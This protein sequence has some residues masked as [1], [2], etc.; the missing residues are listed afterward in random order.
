MELPVLHK[1]CDNRPLPPLVPAFPRKR[2]APAE[3]IE[4]VA[5]FFKMFA[6]PVRLRIMSLLAYRGE[7][8]VSHL[9]KALKLPQSTVSRHLAQLREMRLIRLRYVG[10]STYYGLN[11]P[12][13]LS[14]GRL[15]LLD[16]F[17]W[18]H[19]DE[20]GCLGSKRSD[21]RNL[22]ALTSGPKFKGGDNVY[23][24]KRTGKGKVTP[25]PAMVLKHSRERI[26]ITTAGPTD[27]EFREIHVSPSTLIKRW[28]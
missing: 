17:D 13:Q 27:G 1:R 6:D 18:T 8:M 26:K 7:V 23:W 5:A 12:Y 2:A 15:V 3:P 21:I 14:L 16:L 20:S 24:L 19:R 25:I 28:G 9:S 11:D 22:D 4:L 10:S